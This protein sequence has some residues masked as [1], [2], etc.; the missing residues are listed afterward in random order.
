MAQKYF[1]ELWKACAKA[2]KPLRV[3]LET[4]REALAPSKG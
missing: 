1:R 3:E 2:D 4:A